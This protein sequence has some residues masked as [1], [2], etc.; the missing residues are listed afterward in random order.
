MHF[1]SSA[2]RRCPKEEE[3]L[4]MEDDPDELLITKGKF[5]PKKTDPNECLKI[6]ELR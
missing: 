5:K 2:P 6:K 3:M 1:S 4:K